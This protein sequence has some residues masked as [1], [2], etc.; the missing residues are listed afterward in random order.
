MDLHSGDRARFAPYYAGGDIFLHN[1]DGARAEIATLLTL[2]APE[3][4]DGR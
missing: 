1:A 4:F 3:S 2:L